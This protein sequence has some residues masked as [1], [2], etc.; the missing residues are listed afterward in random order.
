MKVDEANDDRPVTP[1]TDDKRKAFVNVND[2][3]S[4]P[5]PEPGDG[6]IV[7]GDGGR[8]RGEPR[9]V[10]WRLWMHRLWDGFHLVLAG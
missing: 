4:I 6:G 3:V 9:G 2:E 1:V 7:R 8:V 10:D 5:Q